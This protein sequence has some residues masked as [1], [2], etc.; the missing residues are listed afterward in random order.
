VVAEE[1]LEPRRVGLAGIGVR[2]AGPGELEE[3]L[4]CVDEEERDRDVDA[5]DGLVAGEMHLHRQAA[6]VE[7]VAVGQMRVPAAVRQPGRHGYRLAGQVRRP[8][9]P[10]R[11]G[12]RREHALAERT[13]RVHGAEAVV[14]AA[15]ELVERCDD[16]LVQ[17][18]HLDL[19][20]GF[21]AESTR[22]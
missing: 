7:A 9:Q 3:A 19:Q 14:G 8:A 20:L 1:L 4:G 5:V 16:L 2:H 18:R 11:F 13:A 21:R 22:L 15:R 12:A 17:A 6:A 10:R